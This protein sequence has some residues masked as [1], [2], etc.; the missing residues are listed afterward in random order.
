MPQTPSSVFDGAYAALSKG[1]NSKTSCRSY[2]TIELFQPLDPM[3]AIGVDLPCEGI[4]AVE[5]EMRN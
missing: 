1:A 2:P 5:L 4:S 3:F